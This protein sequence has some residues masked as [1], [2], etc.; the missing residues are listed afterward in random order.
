[1]GAAAD[2]EAGPESKPWGAPAS[3]GPVGG[4]RCPPIRW[5]GKLEVKARKEAVVRGA[6]WLQGRN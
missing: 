6:Q 2:G 1:M 3:K 4:F 5:K